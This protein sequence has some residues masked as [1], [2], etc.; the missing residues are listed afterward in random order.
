M[1]NEIKQ[2]KAQQDLF[3]QKL[4]NYLKDESISLDERWEVFETIPKFILFSEECL[5]FNGLDK[6]FY[7]YWD[8][9]NKNEIIYVKDIV[10]EEK[11]YLNLLELK[12][13]ILQKGYASFIYNWRD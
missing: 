5:R 2:Y 4:R 12:T 8:S 1:L 9:Y 10:E 7:S 6:I 11:Q 3:E 13:E